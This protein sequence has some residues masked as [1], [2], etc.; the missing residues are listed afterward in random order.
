M[1]VH[2]L[3]IYPFIIETLGK[4]APLVPRV[5]RHDP[6]LAKQLRRV[7]RAIDRICA[8]LYRLVS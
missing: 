4:I 7:R 1:E 3:Q 8:T 6:D 5:A 2:M